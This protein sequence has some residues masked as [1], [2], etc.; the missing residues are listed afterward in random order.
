MKYNHIIAI[1]GN[2]NVGK[3][4]LFNHLA[5]QKHKV[6][7]WPGVTV[8]KKTG[9]LR[10][11]NEDYEIVDLPGIYSFSA[12]SIDEIVARDY[13]L[14]KKGPDV[15][16]NIVDASNFERNIYLTTQLIE[17]QVPIVIALNMLDVA[18]KS[19]ISINAKK[20]SE[21]LGVSIV[22]INAREKKG[23]DELI[24]EM[25]R[26]VHSKELPKKL[27]YGNEIEEAVN[28]IIKSHGD[29]LEEVFHCKKWAALKVLEGDKL[30]SEN[31]KEDGQIFKLIEDLEDRFDE[32]LDIVLAE[33]RY[34]VIGELAA[35]CRTQN[36]KNTKTKSDKVDKIVLH[37]VFGIPIFLMAMWLMFKLAVDF[38][39]AF[40][41]F[42]DQFFG[43]IFVDATGELLK[44]A[45]WLKVFLADGL[46]GGIQTVATFIPP[47][48]LLFLAIAILEDSG[49]MARA[50]FVVDR[51]MRFIG[52][53]GKAFMP[54]LMAFGCNA[55]AILATRTLED[56]GDRKLSIMMN[57]LMSCGARLPVYTLLAGAFFPAMSGTITFS[58]YLVGILLAVLTGFIFK[59]TL[60]KKKTLSPFVMELPPYHAPRLSVIFRNA[61]SRTSVFITRAGKI[62][63][64]IVIFLQIIGNI[65][66]GGR[67]PENENFVAFG[68]D[69]LVGKVGK[70][71]TYPL[72]PM[73]MQEDNWPAAVG[74]F[75]GIFAKEAII[76]T[77]DTAY[78][79]MK[80]DLTKDK[81]KKN[82]PP[83][84]K[85]DFWA[86]IGGAFHSI[87]V[88]LI[89]AN[90][91][92][93]EWQAGILIKPSF[94]LPFYEFFAGLSEKQDFEEQAL[95]QKAF[96]DETIVDPVKR[97]RTASAA[98]Y[99]YLLFI[100][101]YVPC[102]AVMGA[103]YKE[104][105]GKWLTIQVVY[106][107]GL[108]Y[109]VSTA[110][111]QISKI[112]I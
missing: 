14:Q 101:I 95:L 94:Y 13:I 73:G 104:I 76:G 69:S 102:V 103:V 41:D 40:I 19:E 26:V 30:V 56:E 78:K 2:P 98:A 110:F 22:E 6:G 86:G 1:A 28:T 81:T 91:E 5:G 20:L 17:M 64:I 15:I 48:F 52:L 85:F 3:T 106:L 75:T 58:I 96:T 12:R 38:G 109:I 100:L 79:S 71:L 87:K 23:I 31:I 29:V 77:L 24:K 25:V 27:N 82:D 105:G 84:E 11:D 53:P 65:S 97:R 93:G 21:M 67:K 51:F 80:A 59:K 66:L 55:P 32:E 61:W 37:R 18:N 99:A 92:K 7:N 36:T 62:V 54:M 88:N 34:E 45:G 63:V 8:E 50:A 108:A 33:K 49:Y 74:L 44:D 35:S 42:F 111:F 46:G 60:I 90:D 57:P 9:E 47:I 112:F 89:G 16:V 39:G 83:K 72:K 68:K 10:Y 4:S 43:T 107:T 70:L